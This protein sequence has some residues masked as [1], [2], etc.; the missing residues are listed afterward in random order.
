M[1][2]RIISHFIIVVFTILSVQLFAQVDIKEIENRLRHDIGALAHD[3]MFGRDAGSAS[4]KVAASFIEESFRKCGLKPYDALTGN[5]LKPFDFGYNALT[6]CKLKINEH[7]FKQGEEFG[8]IPGSADG[9]ISSAEIVKLNANFLNSLPGKLLYQGKVVLVNMSDSEIQTD[10]GIDRTFEIIR[11]ATDLGVSACLLYNALPGDFD[12]KL[13]DPDSV[14]LFKIPV[15]YIT[16]SIITSLKKMDNPSCEIEVRIERKRPTAYNVI[17]FLDRG[18]EKTVVIGGHFD[19]VGTPGVPI[20]KIGD[21]KIHNGADD[22]AS[23]AAAVMELARWACQQKDLKYNYLF[24]AFSAEE[25][26]LFGSWNFCNSDDFKKYHFVW[27][28][29][30]DMVGRLGWNG[31]NRLTVQGLA[32]SSKWKEV[33]KNTDH[34]DLTISKIKGAPAY[35]DHYPFLM[36]HVPVIYYTTG[37]EKEYHKPLDDP[38][39]INYTGEAAII[40]YLQRIILHVETIGDPGFKKVSGWNNFKAFIK[41]FIFK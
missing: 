41:E 30:L 39:L 37:L 11:N 3:S 27:M 12:K 18:A 20:P 40:E 22:N 5:Y 13:F 9:N 33:I 35:S 31:T 28:L 23:G 25:K 32:S 36:H 34:P 24:I 16:S 10:K 1:K 7:Q 21:P 4:E 15:V 26:G 2:T 17:G 29:N 8:A 6:F 19:H 14:P 38:E